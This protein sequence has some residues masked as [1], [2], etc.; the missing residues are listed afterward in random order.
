M[1]FRVI[2]KIIQRHLKYHL[3]VPLIVG[4][5]I[6]YGTHRL[7]KKYEGAF[8]IWL[9][10]LAPI[11]GIV[12]AYLVVM[13]FVIKEETEIGIQRIQSTKLENA[14]QDAT[15]FL[16]IGVIELKEWFE[17]SP[18]V[19]LATIMKRKIENPDFIYNRVLIFSKSAFEDLKNQF[20]NYYYAKAL[21]D[22]H[23]AHGIGLGY[24]TPAEMRAILEEFDLN[25][26]KAIGAYP[27]WMP[28]W[29][30]TI[31]PKR[32]RGVWNRRLALAVVR[33]GDE[34]YFLHFSKHGVVVDVSEIPDAITD[35]ARKKAY[36]KLVGKIRG[37]VFKGAAIDPDH[38]FLNYY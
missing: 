5:L 27:L 1:F 6:E 26:G 2:R 18:Q 25:E 16:G 15:G 24:L 13:Y 11:L 8:W 37:K 22:I 33:Y 7:A 35:D 10:L 17:P 23:K 32:W 9:D 29:L 31:T 14:L 21:I 19:Y 28:G 3:L 12:F 20:L 38:D 4:I 30:L 36:N 34:D